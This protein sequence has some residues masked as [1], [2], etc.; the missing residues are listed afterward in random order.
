MLFNSK[1]T[2]Q[3][4]QQAP[5]KLQIILHQRNVHKTDILEFVSSHLK[6]LADLHGKL[7]KPVRC[8]ALISYDSSILVISLKLLCTI[9]NTGSPTSITRCINGKWLT[10]VNDWSVI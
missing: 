8:Q 1:Q 5:Y 2:S 9:A 6:V 4:T 7:L 3:K 10:Q